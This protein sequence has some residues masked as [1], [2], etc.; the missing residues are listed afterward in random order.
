MKTFKY[1]MH[2]I[3]EE[4]LSPEARDV[5][6]A[7]LCDW[8]DAQEGDIVA[9]RRSVRWLKDSIELTDNLSFFF[10]HGGVPR[11]RLYLELDPDLRRSI[12]DA[13]IMTTFG[14]TS[15]SLHSRIQEAAEFQLPRVYDFEMIYLRDAVIFQAISPAYFYDD[16]INL[17]THPE[18]RLKAAG[19]LGT[20][21]INPMLDSS[22]NRL[23]TKASAHQKVEQWKSLATAHEFYVAAGG[24]GGFNSEA[25]LLCPQP[26]AHIIRSEEP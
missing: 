18:K 11:E 16:H 24:M 26:P 1:A 10:K 7:T 3:E 17:I 14:I 22:E 5:V 6:E 15:A 2:A 4:Y 21:I 23:R 20:I 12:A 8:S 9:I 13:A 25:I 19:G